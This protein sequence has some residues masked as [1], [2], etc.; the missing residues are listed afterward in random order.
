MLL[1]GIFLETTR[2]KEGDYIK[3]MTKSIGKFRT[4]IMSIISKY[5]KKT[6]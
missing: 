4:E 3:T 2:L 5:G 1:C 6:S